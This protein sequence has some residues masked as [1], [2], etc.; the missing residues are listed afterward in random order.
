MKRVMALM[1]VGL[2]VVLAL[3]VAVAGAMPDDGA[4][5]GQLDGG[6]SAGQL[7]SPENEEVVIDCL[8]RTTGGRLTREELKELRIEL[9]LNGYTGSYSAAVLVCALP[10]QVASK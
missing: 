8:H 6:R 7:V 3:M 5:S 9:A 1:M 4:G 2:L 10:D